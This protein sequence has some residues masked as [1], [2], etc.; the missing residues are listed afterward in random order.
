MENKKSKKTLGQ[1]FST[2]MLSIAIFLLVILTAFNIFFYKSPIVGISMQPTFNAELEEGRPTSEYEQSNIKDKAY[3]YRFG[4]GKR[5]DVVMVQIVEDGKSKLLIKRL[6][7]VGGDSVDIKKDNSS[8]EYYLYIN[9]EKQEEAYIKYQSRMNICFENLKE[10]KK[11][12][13]ISEDQSIVLKENEVFVLGDNRGMSNDSS[14]FGPVDKSQIK[15]VV[16]FVVGHKDNL[17]TYLW[18]KIF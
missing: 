10:Y 2:V 8:N 14:L 11:S 7:A 6:V 3:V 4:K 16:A 13:G 15:G 18:K 1:V 12:H 17:I 9:G 5:G